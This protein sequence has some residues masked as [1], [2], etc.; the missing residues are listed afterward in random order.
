VIIVY[1]IWLLIHN[2]I[3]FMALS[4]GG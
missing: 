4:S 3:N 2:I 1:K